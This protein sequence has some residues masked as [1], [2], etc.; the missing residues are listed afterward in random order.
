M[1]ICVYIC[2][3]TCNNSLILRRGY[4][5]EETEEGPLRHF[6]RKKGTGK[7]II[8]NLRQ[9]CTALLDGMYLGEEILKMR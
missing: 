4:E 6:G 9:L 2:I 3:Y 8:P 5:L 1:N 7:T